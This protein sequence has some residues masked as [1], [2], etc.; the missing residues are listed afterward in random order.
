MASSQTQG[1]CYL[2]GK[3]L[4]KTLGKTAMKNHV[5]KEHTDGPEECFLLK[6]EG[7]HAKQYWLYVDIAKDKPLN[8]LDSFLRKIWLECCGHLSAFHPGSNPYTHT[9]IGKSRKAGEFSVGDVITHEYDMGSSTH[10]LITFV[11]ETGRPQQR[12]A[13]RLLARNIPPVFECASCGAPADYICQDCVYS[14]GDPCYCSACIDEHEHDVFADITNSPR[15]GECG[16]DG[17]LDV[18]EYTP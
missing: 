18:Y 1:N 13:V 15:C 12:N 8:T 5:L 7:L 14:S 10:C 3:T 6:I 2:C 16:Y 9:N 17:G 11:G 4:G